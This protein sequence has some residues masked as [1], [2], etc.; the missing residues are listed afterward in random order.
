MRVTALALTPLLALGAC[1][2]GPAQQAGAPVVAVS[3]TAATWVAPGAYKFVLDS[4]CG[5]RALL[6]RFRVRVENGEVVDTVGLDDAA[7]RALML[8]VADLVPTLQQLEQQAASAR[9]AGGSAEVERDPADGHP[10][11]L[12]IDPEPGAIDDE[13]CYTVEDY[14]IGGRV[15]LSPSPS[16]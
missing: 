16:R 9:A 5:E 6:G 10:V 4:R 13:A 14:S 7:K 1:A 3:S 2:N 8:R 15:T 12:T 11:R